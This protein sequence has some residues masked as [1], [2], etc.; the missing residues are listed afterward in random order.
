LPFKKFACRSNK[1][2]YILIQIV[3]TL[4]ELPVK[5]MR[6]IKAISIIDRRIFDSSKVIHSSGGHMISRTLISLVGA[7]AL[8][9]SLTACGTT[10]KQAV[11][12][13]A[14]AAIGG[15]AGHAASGGSTIGT[16][17]GAAVGGAIGNEVAK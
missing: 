5:C 15:A 10:S 14:G 4:L 9:S 12:I 6:R 3:N 2:S 1:A 16:I 11:G 8:A 13:G 7:V 17:G